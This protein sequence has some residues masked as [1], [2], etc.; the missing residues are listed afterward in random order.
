MARSG[1]GR[2]AA[3]CGGVCLAILAVTAS[4]V[5]ARPAAFTNE[6]VARG[7]S[8]LVH[9]PPPGPYNIFGSGVAFADLDGDQ[10]EDLI[11]L[12]R[13]DGLAGFFENDGTGHFIDRSLSVGVPALNRPSSLTAADYD[14]DGD[15]DVYIGCFIENNMFLRNDGGF[16]FTDVSVSSGLHDPGAAMGCAWGDLNGDTW[17]DLYVPNRTGANGDTT[18]NRV[19]MNN[20]NGTFSSNGDAMGLS[21]AS[22]PTLVVACLDY[23]RDGD[24]DIYAGNDKGTGPLLW[25]HLFRNDGAGVFTDVT[26]AS[27]TEA[28]VDCMGIAIG[29]WDRNGWQ[30]LYVTNTPPGNVLLMANG[31][32]TFTDQTLAANVGS[33]GIGWATMF[34]DYDNDGWEELYVCDMIMPNRFYNAD[35]VWPATDLGP[36]LGVADPGVSFC[37]AY[38]DIDRD[39]D[40]DFA[41]TTLGQ[42]L[43][44]YIN[45]EGQTRNWS[46]LRVV[47]QGKNH[48][49]VGVQVDLRTGTIWQMREVHNGANYKSQN[50]FVLHFG[51]D[52]ATIVDEMLVMWPGGTTRTLTN[53]PG[54]TAWTLYP[55]ERLGDANG[56]A[57]WDS[58]DW[59]TFLGC[60]DADTATGV[61]PGCEMM[62]MDGNAVVDCGDANALL[63]LWT[64]GGTAPTPPPT[65]CITCGLCPNVSAG[66][67]VGLVDLDD[68]NLVLFNLGATG[69][70]PGTLGDT[71]C[72][73]DTDLS[74]LNSVLFA[75]GTVVPCGH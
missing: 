31:D 22:D 68:L 24:A 74:D 47:G 53:Y 14:G 38:A 57:Q 12:G 52:T 75:F 17:L 72:D 15:L 16:T 37:S 45:N 59:T 8:Y 6:A 66:G 49:G 19:F 64:G 10:D 28:D 46:R 55:P 1:A 67:A 42:N 51:L 40:L 3:S 58:Q 25:N 44:L 54:N 9:N 70:A 62:D 43:R 2:G 41:V 4:Q 5:T 30:D 56:D 69:S 20:K 27:G 34:F 63:A 11:V 71:D 65:L 73:G 35:G 26:A 60:L 29:D 39:G 18:P 21:M 36:T 13:V 7:V 23:D 33:Y 32:G 61:T 50:E 48:F